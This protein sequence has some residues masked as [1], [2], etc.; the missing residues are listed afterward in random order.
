MCVSIPLSQFTRIQ[1]SRQREKSVTIPLLQFTRLLHYMVSFP[2]CKTKNDEI[3]RKW[4]KKVCVSI[5]V[6]AYT[7]TSN[8]P[9]LELPGKITK[10]KLQERRKCVFLPLCLSL[11][12]E[13]KKK[14]RFNSSIT[15]YTHQTL[16][17]LN[18]RA[19]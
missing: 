8:S 16:L 3:G 13:R 14:N 17:V 12:G 5:S 7:H 2:N 19:K 18:W 15:A 1:H 9:L 10:Q 4:R 6:T 11:H